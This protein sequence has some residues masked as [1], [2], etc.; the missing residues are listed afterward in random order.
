[1]VKPV[2]QLID[3]IGYKPTLVASGGITLGGAGISSALL[4][5]GVLTLLS[6]QGVALPGAFASLGNLHLVGGILFTTT[7]P[8][9]LL[10][11]S[12][13]FIFMAHQVRATLKNRPSAS[14]THD[15][16]ALTPS[17]ETPLE[18]LRAQFGEV[19]GSDGFV[20]IEIENFISEDDLSFFDA[21]LEIAI[22]KKECE[23]F[24]SESTFAYMSVWDNQEIY[25]NLHYN[26]DEND[27]N[28]IFGN[29][30]AAK[31]ID[32]KESQL[33]HGFI[34]HI[35]KKFPGVEATIRDN[36]S[37]ILNLKNYKACQTQ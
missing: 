23:G 35:K 36:G 32:L 31:K 21:L 33:L 8:V 7:G 15:E 18:A 34:I 25:I 12:A 14:F 6:S 20:K 13:F 17:K 16:E 19:V 1:M 28:I 9:G 30:N 5:I 27:K 2:Q 24:K 4:F 29:E 37:I 11:S 22:I 10:G 26:V 3:S